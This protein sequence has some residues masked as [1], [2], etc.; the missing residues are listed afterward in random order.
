MRSPEHCCISKWLLPELTDV[1]S[2]RL[3]ET[4]CS[5]VKLARSES[6]FDW[7]LA[8]QSQ[9]HIA[10]DGRCVFCVESH[11]GLM[12]RCFFTVWQLL[13]CPCGACSMMRGWACR[14]SITQ[15]AA[16]SYLS[17]LWSFL[18]VVFKI[19]YSIYKWKDLSNQCKERLRQPN[20]MVEL[21]CPSPLQQWVEY[22]NRLR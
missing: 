5:S 16:V 6:T 11:L 13:S 19:Y 20:P 21:D 12:T 7:Q 14:L 8:S 4:E 1:A 22:S 10:T 3:T 15:S 18:Y 9:T 2:K 17:W